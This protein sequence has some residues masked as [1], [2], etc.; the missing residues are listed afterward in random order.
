MPS[1]I[2]ENLAAFSDYAARF[3]QNHP[4]SADSITLKRDHSLRVLEYAQRIINSLGLGRTCA[5][6]VSLAALFHDIGRYEQLVRYGTYNDH[7][8]INHGLLGSRVLR[9]EDFLAGVPLEDRRLII[10]AVMLHNRRTVPS[11]VTGK[12][13]QT[14]SIIRDADKLDIMPVVINNIKNSNGRSSDV[15]LNL[16]PHPNKYTDSVYDAVM[17]NK[18]VHYET[19]HW[20]NDFKLALCGWVTDFNFT[21]SRQLL[22][23]RGTLDELLHLLPETDNMKKLAL[24]IKSILQQ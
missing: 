4:E 17:S 10:G 18:M 21:V 20:V 13:H 24:H 3:L 12:L 5:Y 14:I 2:S 19:M 6:T 11:M 22:L 1:D 7:Q 9:S 15:T 23:K 16:D 8:S